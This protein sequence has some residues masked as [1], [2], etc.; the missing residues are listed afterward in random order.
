MSLEQLDKLLLQRR[1]VTSRLRVLPNSKHHIPRH[2]WPHVPDT[3]KKSTNSLVCWEREREKEAREEEKE[4]HQSAC[5]I[6]VW[7]EGE[8]GDKSFCH[9]PPQKR[10]AL[11]RKKGGRTARTR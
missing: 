9:H 7:H 4:D 3:R 1:V 8:H 6:A 11:T 10:V 2:E 5:L